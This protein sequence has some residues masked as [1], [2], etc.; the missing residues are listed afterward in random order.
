MAQVDILDT[1]HAALRPGA[2]VADP[3]G[4]ALAHGGSPASG[5]AAKESHRNVTYDEFLNCLI[6]FSQKL[7]PPP[8]MARGAGVNT[9][10]NLT[11]STAHA[12]SIGSLTA[13]KSPRGGGGFG[14]AST[15]ATWV[16]GER[17]LNEVMSPAQRAAQKARTGLDSVAAREHTERAFQRLLMEHVLPLA[18]RRAPLTVAHVLRDE[19]VQHLFSLFETELLAL[20]AFYAAESMKRV[21]KLENRTGGA[22]G[23][24]AMGAAHGVAGVGAA[25]QAQLYSGGGPAP[26]GLRGNNGVKAK[27]SSPGGKSAASARRNGGGATPGGKDGKGGGVDGKSGDGADGDEGDDGKPGR[28]RAESQLY[29][30]NSA[31]YGRTR[32]LAYLEV[33]GSQRIE[34]HN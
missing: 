27:A 29:S 23:H 21:S 9:T 28:P 16:D 7:Y 19:R 22:Q 14:A 5:A 24:S 17:T 12:T 6:R 15:A 1:S 10:G 13:A 8:G 33:R 25:A 32:S 34:D 18:S 26:G 20:Y 11:L 2:F 3:V 30:Y 31:E 4:E